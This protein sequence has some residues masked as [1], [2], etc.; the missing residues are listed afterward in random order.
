MKTA[1]TKTIV[2]LTAIQ[3]FIIQSTQAQ[4]DGGIVP[5]PKS[6]EAC[7]FDRV[8]EIPVREY[9]GEPDISIPIYT[10]DCGDIRVPIS[11]D[12]QGQAI[13]VDQEATWVGL[14]WLLNAGG[15]ITSRCSPHYGE[16]SG[17]KFKDDWRHMSS[18]LSFTK[19][20]CDGGEFSNLYYKVDGAHPDWRG[21]YGANWFQKTSE[22]EVPDGLRPNDISYILYHQIL[23]RK[24]NGCTTYHASFLGNSFTFVRD[25]I[26]GGCY[27]TGVNK[28][29]TIEITGNITI[30][31]GKGIKYI[32]ATEE[33]GRT[34][35]LDIN[36]SFCT[37]DATFYLSEIV[38][39]SGRKISFKYVDGGGIAPIHTVMETL[40]ESKYPTSVI[41]T[42][43]NLMT[44]IGK[45]TVERIMSPYYT[46]GTKRLTEIETD[47]ELIVFTPSSEKRKDLNG[48]TYAL[49]NITIYHK[50]GSEKTFIK[51]FNF[52]YSYF[53]KNETG[54]NT[55]KD[56]W[57]D[58][59][60]QDVYGNLYP[61]DSFMYYRLKLNSIREVNA[62]SA[63][64][65]KYS[66]KYYEDNY[67]PC[68]KSAAVD[69]WGYYNG[70]ENSNG[71]YHTLLPKAWENAT[72]DGVYDCPLKNVYT[73]ADRRFNENY[74]ITGMLRSICYPTGGTA[75]I[76][77]EPHQFLNFTY[78][79]HSTTGITEKR[80]SLNIV[81]SNQ[82]TYSPG[83]GCN[84][85][86]TVFTINTEKHFSMEA[87]FYKSNQQK[88]A[89]WSNLLS[90]TVILF[91]YKSGQSEQINPIK[92]LHIEPGDT[93]SATNMLN[94][95][96]DLILSAGKYLLQ[97]Y[98]S[99]TYSDSQRAF[100]EISANLYEKNVRKASQ[101]A[102][103]RVKSIAMYD[104]RQTTQKTYSY[105]L[106]DNISAGKL[107]SPVIFARQK[108]LVYQ[109]EKYVQGQNLP[110]AHEI[111]YW[112]INGH[113]MASTSPVT[114][115][116]DRVTVT[117]SGKGSI[118]RNFW[119]R[120]WGSS[121]FFDYM[122]RT[123]DP[124][125]GWPVE[126]LHYSGNGEL[127]R[128]ITDSYKLR[129]TKAPLLNASIE[130]IYIGANHVTGGTLVSIN[131]YAHVLGG[132]C[133]QIYLYPAAQFSLLS[134]QHTIKDYSGGQSMTINRETLYNQDN[135]R[136][137]VMTTTTSD[138]NG[139]SIVET[140]YPHDMSTSSGNISQL[141]SKHITAVPL[142]QLVSVQNPEGTFVVGDSRYKYNDKGAA[143]N[144]FEYKNAS[145]ISRSS[146]ATLKQNYSFSGYNTTGAFEYNGAG[147]LRSITDESGTVMTYIWGYANR[148]P[149]AIIR[150][151]TSSQVTAALGGAAALDSFEKSV[152][153]TLTGTA[154]HNKLKGIAGA[155]VTVC[156]YRPLV[157]M[158]EMIAPNGE[159]TTYDYDTFLRLAKE[160]DHNGVVVKSYTYNYKH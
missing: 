52:D 1:L 134:S 8:G 101:G 109:P 37:Y 115:G 46:I 62:N 146:F 140:L 9:T 18:Q 137:S 7:A 119:N 132:G 3:T 99:F 158:V 51:R 148:Y 91:K 10:L 111:H 127:L 96:S 117:Q 54:G 25:N 47:D 59:A 88:S 19:I 77:Y 129:C 142:E 86:D 97:V 80:L 154:L 125:N 11:L 122:Q 155:S 90:H 126:E 139:K 123:E 21:G 35:G 110:I 67:L 159:T 70:K 68:K 28:D 44:T 5:V 49:K 17:T 32:F 130:N 136:D 151:A 42:R 144:S 81:D 156:Y 92:I 53:E 75:T 113:N 60:T 128:S 61:N 20:H 43:Q 33:I 93:V 124:R 150:C 152:I 2:L 84:L 157:G 57:K 105:T 94:Y 23:D 58:M 40:Y 116:Y 34:E 29:F 13:R 76:S 118:E 63:Q 114:V 72:D 98:P 145:P 41:I 120:R 112:K 87:T 78:N 131:E 104:G 16:T 141:L 64:S 55:L 66:F 45:H 26:N 106:E 74:A 79:N 138:T 69:Y 36:P 147:C 48:T 100:Y 71:S 108:I 15:A 65:R 160:T 89:Y 50:N 30:T 102:G 107:M 39:P 56:Y 133:M 143:I 82:P 135:C 24:Q 31:D 153:P 103:L 85:R 14:N 149:V 38:S 121:T 6:P 4:T 27:I 95:Q 12:Y 83:A 73:G 22:L